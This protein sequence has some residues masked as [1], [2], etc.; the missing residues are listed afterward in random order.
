M[1]NFC[2]Y[3]RNQYARDTPYENLMAIIT[4][5]HRNISLKTIRVSVYVCDTLIYP[6][7]DNL[8]S[9]SKWVNLGAYYV[10]KS[11]RVLLLWSKSNQI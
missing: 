7:S 4:H 3:N 10:N 5:L 1:N 11:C 8:S 9:K 6:F 2:E